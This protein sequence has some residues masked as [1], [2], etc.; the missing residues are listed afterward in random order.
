MPAVENGKEPIVEKGLYVPIVEYGRNELYVEKGVDIDN[1]V[2]PNGKKD[3][4]A[5]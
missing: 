4:N 1:E 3:E 5:L 2:Y